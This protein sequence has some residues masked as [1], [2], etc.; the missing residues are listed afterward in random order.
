MH[1]ASLTADRLRWWNELN[2]DERSRL[3]DLVRIFLATKTFEA[4][5]GFE[6]CEDVKVTIAAEASLLVL[7]LGHEWYRDVGAIIVYPSTVNPPRP[8]RHRRRHRT[9]RADRAFR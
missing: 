6:A 4:A 3:E 8:A 1:G 5:A 2:A 9:P 7:G